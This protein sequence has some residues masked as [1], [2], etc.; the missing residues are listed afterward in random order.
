MSP[1]GEPASRPRRF[2]DPFWADR[3][4]TDPDRFAGRRTQVDAVIDSLYQTAHG[5]GRHTIITGDRGIGKSSL[6][7]QAVVLA[8]GGTTLAERLVIDLGLSQGRGFEFAIGFHETNSD[9]T[10]AGLVDNV[11]RKFQSRG[12]RLLSGLYTYSAQLY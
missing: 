8:E 10:L 1:D 6:L 11:L 9:E 7:Q 2:A 12:Q 4:L 5:I 3:P